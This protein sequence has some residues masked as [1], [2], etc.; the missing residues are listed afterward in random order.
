MWL[1][2]RV[3]GGECEK[4]RIKEESV[5]KSIV[6]FGLYSEDN[7]KSLKGQVRR[8]ARHFC[9]LERSLCLPCQEWA[10][11]KKNCILGD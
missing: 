7:E 11:R 9:V 5:C 3:C 1:E 6:K 2:F 4:A 8:V 10:G